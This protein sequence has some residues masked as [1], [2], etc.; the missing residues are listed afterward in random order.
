MD[1]SV[2]LIATLVLF[3]LGLNALLK[4]ASPAGKGFP[5]C[6]ECGNVGKRQPL[7]GDDLPDEIEYQLHKLKLPADKV[8]SRYVCPKGCTHMWY[9]PR[10][11]D[12]DKGVIRSRRL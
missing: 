3:G 9:L 5:T 7:G 12:M 11:G 4:K 8:V 2:M 6:I 1:Q 10:I